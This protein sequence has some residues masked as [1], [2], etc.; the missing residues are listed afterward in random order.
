MLE[1]RSRA[2]DSRS[3]AS[4]PVPSWLL[5]SDTL[6][7]SKVDTVDTPVAAH[8]A[9]GP[10]SWL[11]SGHATRRRSVSDCHSYQSLVERPHHSP[12]ARSRT[13]YTRSQSPESLLEQDLE[14]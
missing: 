11:S 1:Q 3:R 12:R 9:A 13:A 10:K 8:T 4:D 5:P 14:R 6:T 7:P 2:G